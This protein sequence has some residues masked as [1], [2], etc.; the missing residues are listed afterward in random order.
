MGRQ[1]TRQ[2]GRSGVHAGNVCPFVETPDHGGQH[3]CAMGEADT[4]AG[5]AGERPTGQQGRGGHPGLQRH[6]RTETDSPSGHPGQQILVAGMHQQ[7]CAELVGDGEEAVETLVTELE[8]GD[9][10]ADF[11]ADEPWPAHATPQFVD[12]PVRILQRDRAQCRESGGMVADETGEEFVLRRGQF[13]GAW[14]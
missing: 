11:G 8:S 12:G 3:A 10:G 9:L 5:S 13:R 14:D 2:L 7:Q 6:A 4:H 1:P